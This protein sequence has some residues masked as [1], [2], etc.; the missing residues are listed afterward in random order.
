[1]THPVIRIL[2]VCTAN[3]CRSPY[4]QFHLQRGL[5]SL[6]PGIFQVRSAGTMAVEGQA[7]DPSSARYVEL[8]GEHTEGFTARMLTPTM[9]QEADLVLTMTTEHRSAVL[10][11][12]P[13][14]LKRT[15][16]VVEFA[17]LAASIPPEH[18]RDTP[19]GST[20]ADVVA[21]WKVLPRL[22]SGLRSSVKNTPMDV[23]DPYRRGDAAYATMVQQLSAALD[24]I[25][26][27]EQRWQHG[28]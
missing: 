24:V 27:A 14:A 15:F 7:M 3:I 5:D 8:L 23:A 25:I 21:R 28:T 6:S 13:R 18:E 11:L 12:T 2:T 16:T 19:T 20:P 22:L 9:V 1:M 4:A 10:E 17:T 26:K